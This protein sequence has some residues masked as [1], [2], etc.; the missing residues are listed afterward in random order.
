L[1]IPALPLRDSGASS[2]RA[3][4]KYLRP[5]E[6]CRHTARRPRG[7][8]HGAK[9]HVIMTVWDAAGPLRARFSLSSRRGAPYWE[10]RSGSAALGAH[11]PAQ[12]GPMWPRCTAELAEPSTPRE[13]CPLSTC[14]TGCLEP[15]CGARSSTALPANNAARLC[16]RFAP[17][18]SWISQPLAH[19]VSPPATDRRN[20]VSAKVNEPQHSPPRTWASLL[21]RSATDA[22][23]R[24]RP[25]YAH[26]CTSVLPG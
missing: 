1:F 6:Q 7:G 22:A 13:H 24:R 25:L 14:Q 19:T 23:N 2:R 26:L 20:R 4:P 21:G 12:T 11:M 16:V 17:T 10:R 3:T 15:M 8:P 5:S 9:R 18:P